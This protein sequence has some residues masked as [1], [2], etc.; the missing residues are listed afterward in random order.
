MQIALH[1]VQLLSN[2]L[3]TD[4]GRRTDPV[5]R[6]R[7]E[8]PEGASP[9]LWIRTK[10]DVRQTA[11]KAQPPHRA[12]AC[13]KQRPTSVKETEAAEPE[14]PDAAE[15]PPAPPAGPARVQPDGSRRPSAALRAA[16]ERPR[17]RRRAGGCGGAKALTVAEEDEISSSEPAASR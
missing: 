10:N 4:G 17:R 1:T 5:V 16:G 15:P 2:S 8:R 6:R 3:R 9:A 11:G 12:W 13:L 7:G 14:L